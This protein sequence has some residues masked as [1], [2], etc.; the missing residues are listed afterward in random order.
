MNNDESIGLDN[1]GTNSSNK[2]TESKKETVKNELSNLLLFLVFLLFV[3]V[4]FGTL[5]FKILFNTTWVKAF[6]DTITTVTTLGANY[7]NS[8]ETNTQLIFIAIYNIITT[9]LF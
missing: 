7:Q 9:T 3:A 4:V 6:Y 5:M 1:E 2:V 8:P